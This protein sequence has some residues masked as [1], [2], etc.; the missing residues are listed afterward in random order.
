MKIIYIVLTAALFSGCIFASNQGIAGNWKGE[1][2]CMIKD[3]PCHDEHVIYTITEPDKAGKLQIQADKVVNGQR[4]N[5][6]TLDCQFDAKAA[7]IT[8]PMKNGEWSFDVKGDT[9][10]GTLTLPDGRLFRRINVK[11]EK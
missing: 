1:S 6:G 7:T 11:K 3:S 10:T 4:E 5:L 9:M 8:C 2:I